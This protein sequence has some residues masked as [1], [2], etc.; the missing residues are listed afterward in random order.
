M[1]A[2]IR[3]V[4]AE[5]IKPSLFLLKKFK[6][7][8]ITVTSFECYIYLRHIHCSCSVYSVQFT[9]YYI[10]MSCEFVNRFFA[11]FFFIFQVN[12]MHIHAVYSTHSNEF[13]VFHRNNNIWCGCLQ[14]HISHMNIH[15][16]LT[17]NDILGEYTRYVQVL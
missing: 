8:W 12:P 7:L 13:L 16:Y 1:C 9:V 10:L 4:I 15:I 3:P 14:F 5:W 2:L 6:H 17:N 11:L